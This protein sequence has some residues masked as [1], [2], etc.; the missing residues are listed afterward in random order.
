MQARFSNPLPPSYNES[1]NEQIRGLLTRA[2]L[3]L[4]P[5]NELALLPPDKLVAFCQTVIN[6]R[7]KPSNDLSDARSGLLGANEFLSGV[8]T[9]LLRKLPLNIFVSFSLEKQMILATEDFVRR[10]VDCGV[11]IH[12]LC[13]LDVR[14]L[15]NAHA[16]Y[17]KNLFVL[18]IYKNS[19]AGEK[20]VHEIQQWIEQQVAPPP[21]SAEFSMDQRKHKEG[22]INSAP[23]MPPVSSIPTIPFNRSE[24]MEMVDFFQ[25]G[26][27]KLIR[28]IDAIEIQ[29]AIVRKNQSLTDVADALGLIEDHAKSIYDENRFSHLTMANTLR[30]KI[31]EIIQPTKV[32]VEKEMQQ[33]NPNDFVELNGRKLTPDDIKL[34]KNL[35]IAE[36]SFI[37]RQPPVH[38]VLLEHLLKIKKLLIEDTHKMSPHCYIVYTP[39]TKENEAE[40][41][42]VKPFLTVLYEHLTAAGIR[43]I[44]HS[45]DRDV[46][47]RGFDHFVQQYKGRNDVV[48]IGTP[49]L[50]DYFVQQEYT[51]SKEKRGV[52]TLLEKQNKEETIFPLLISGTPK[53][54]FPPDFQYESTAVANAYGGYSATLKLLVDFFLKKEIVGFTGAYR[55]IWD[56]LNRNIEKIP[57]NNEA[58]YH[59]INQGYHKPKRY[60]EDLS[61]AVSCL[62]DKVIQE[63][64]AVQLPAQNLPSYA[65]DL[66]RARTAIAPSAL[67][68]QQ[69]AFPSASSSSNRPSEVNSE[70]SDVTIWCPSSPKELVG[71][72]GGPNSAEL[73]GAPG[74]ANSPA[75]LVGGSG[76][77]NFFTGLSR[78]PSHQVSDT[79]L[80]ENDKTREESHRAK[81]FPGGLTTCPIS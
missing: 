76:G 64:K 77:S 1:I 62:R 35:L 15:E 44:M 78:Q 72:P 6:S 52:G 71:G 45:R 81:P 42:W 28:Y 69:R 17:N 58:L 11:D 70:A 61:V 22:S 50:R 37:A 49:S 5:I 75:V 65:P 19:E 27:E 12:T 34:K 48:L 40:E 59:E 38:K 3:E 68:L 80:A 25:E 36:Q 32:I 57:E 18:G 60:S 66:F 13:Q 55:Q 74:G 9:L 29:I 67:G 30:R 24:L 7:P 16:L 10:L 43:V 56:Q 2:E 51:W 8:H 63:M 41:Y 47:D 53:T 46:G 31:L 79:D 23:V 54:A 26:Q 21:Y 14:G 4:V 33:Y 73:V 39:P 20:V